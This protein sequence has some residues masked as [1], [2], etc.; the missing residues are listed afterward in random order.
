[1]M[2]S[3]KLFYQAILNYMKKIIPF[4]CIMIILFSCHADLQVND[5]KTANQV[6]DKDTTTYPYKAI[7]S[8]D[9]SMSSD[10]KIAQRV[11]TVWR[12]YENKQIDAMK[13][14]YA[15]TVTYDDANGNHFYGPAKG[16]LA[17]A[18]KEM[19]KL[20]SLR[21]DISMWESV[22]ANDKNEDWVNIWCKERSYPKAG[23]PDTAMMYEKWMIKNGRVYSFNQYYAKLH[24]K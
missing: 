11:L 8:S 24:K 5:A 14:Y 7:Y 15:D 1:M 3:A 2:V 21:F 13:S 16:L 22:H 6:T 4:V 12:M 18:K 19:E 23:K 9:L 17:I 10:P 20:D